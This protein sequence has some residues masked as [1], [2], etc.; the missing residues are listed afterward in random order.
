MHTSYIELQSRAKRWVWWPTSE[1]LVLKVRG[2]SGGVGRDKEFKVI[3]SYTAIQGQH[4]LHK[5]CL[6][7]NKQESF[8]ALC[9]VLGK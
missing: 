7:A 3:P 5:P 6:K 1:I 4:E 2:G 9:I 8:G